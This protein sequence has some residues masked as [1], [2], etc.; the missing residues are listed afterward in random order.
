MI[1]CAIYDRVS[2]EMQVKDGLSLEAQRQ[3]LTDYA[4]AHHYTIVDYYTDEGITARKKMQNRKDLLRLLNDVKADK[5][6]LILVT[7]LDRWFR[8]IKDYH[9]TQSILEAHHCNWKTIFEEY[10]TST[11]NGRFAINIMLSVNENECDRDSE[12]IRSVFAYKKSRQEYLSGKPAYGYRVNEDKHLVKNPDTSPIVEDIF[13]HYFATYSKKETIRYIQNKYGSLAPTPYQIQRVLSSETY[14]GCLYGIS[15][16]CEA[17]ITP[18]QFHKL[19]SVSQTKE[20]YHQTE[21]YLFSSLIPC[22]VCGKN[23]SGFVKKYRR[24]DGSVRITKY[25]RCSNKYTA[26]HNSACLSEKKLE[27]YLLEQLEQETTNILPDSSRPSE[28]LFQKLKKLRLEPGTASPFCPSE[29]IV[30]DGSLKDCLSSARLHEELD[31][32]NN[33]YLKG[34]ITEHFYEERYQTLQSQLNSPIEEE[35]ILPTVRQ[36]VTSGISPAVP[37]ASCWQAQYHALPILH[38]KAFWKSILSSIEIDAV[39]HKPCGCT[40]FP[41]PQDS[42]SDRVQETTLLSRI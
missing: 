40:F 36:N 22:P 18:E 35:F 30:S 7:K 41:I 2:T 23:L 32:L 20:I 4:L 34:R 5:I 25:Y 38:Q 42:I 28:F 31:R 3:A 29:S 17:Y 39:S 26:Y 19:Q 8:N 27:T 9:N 10:D 15:S 33:L 16:Y 37:A 21:P 12:R 11:S 24:K 6:D 1:R 14:A 13:S